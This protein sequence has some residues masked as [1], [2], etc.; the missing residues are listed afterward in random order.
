[1]ELVFS[2]AFVA[3]CLLIAA[4]AL[5]LTEKLKDIFKTGKKATKYVLSVISSAIVTLSVKYIGVNATWGLLLLLGDAGLPEMPEIPT[6][7]IT[8]FYWIAMFGLSWFMA[9]GLYDFIGSIIKK[10]DKK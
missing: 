8:M 2:G 1:M 7:E 9:S 4:A 10:L 3:T 6:E 5:I